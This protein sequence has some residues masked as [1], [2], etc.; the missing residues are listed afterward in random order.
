MDEECSKL[1]LF[2]TDAGMTMAFGERTYFISIEDPF[3]N[4]AKKAVKRGDYVPFY[5]EMAKREGLGKEFR[6]ALV[7]EIG[8]AG[9]DLD[10]LD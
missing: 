5:V 8:K 2:Q 7:S 10:A 9:I 6:D 3:H 1:A 4:I